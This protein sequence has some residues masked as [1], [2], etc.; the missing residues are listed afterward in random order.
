MS[1]EPWTLEDCQGPVGPHSVRPSSSLCVIWSKFSMWNSES[2]PWPPGECRDFAPCLLT[3]LLLSLVL[4]PLPTGC[5]FTGILTQSS[6][7]FACYFECHLLFPLQ[8]ISKSVFKLG[9]LRLHAH[10]TNYLRYISS[11]WLDHPL[12]LIV[13]RSTHIFSVVS[14]FMNKTSLFWLVLKT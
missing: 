7:F 10:L 12:Y 13:G 9:S 3:D 6:S 14:D 8:L 11:W 1:P 4:H 2:Y 5:S